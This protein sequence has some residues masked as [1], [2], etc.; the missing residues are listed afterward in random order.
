[1]KLQSLERNIRGIMELV[2]KSG[3]NTLSAFQ[4]ILDDIDQQSVEADLASKKILMNITAT[5]SDRASTEKRFNQLLQELRQTVLPDLYVNWEQL[6]HENQLIASTL[7][8]FFCG[9]YNLVHFAEAGN[10]SPI[11]DASFSKSSESG[12]LRLVRTTSKALA[13]G[14]M[15]SVESSGTLIHF[16]KENQLNSLP[17]EPFRGNRFNVLFESAVA[18]FF[19]HR[20]I[21][22]F[23]VSNQTNNLLKSVLH[24]IQIS[25]YLAG[26]KA[27][28]LI[29]RLVTGPLW[30]LIEDKNI[31]ILEINKHYL[32]LVNSVQNLDLFMK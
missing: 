3:Q 28:G 7:L 24:D 6:S 23:L 29:S 1:T 4:E 27:L 15:R 31:H 11:R 16:L 9:L 21:Q 32:Q 25:E 19:L 30:C 5:M 13:R 18:L 26:V 2:T 22:G 20:K 8:N 17:L 12:T 10:K 14:Q